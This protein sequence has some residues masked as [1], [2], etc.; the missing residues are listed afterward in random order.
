[1]IK[2]AL[3]KETKTP[4]DA[5]TPITPEGVL[6]LKKKFPELQFYVEP[7]PIRCFKD[8][9]FP[10]KVLIKNEGLTNADIL[11][12]VK[13]VDIPGLIEDKTY[14]FFSHTAK[15][16]AY[17]RGLLKAC[18]NKKIRLIDYE[19]LVKDGQRL[20]AFGNWAGIVGAYNTLRAINQKFSGIELKPAHAYKD[21]SELKA[22]LKNINLP[23]VKIVI[24][25]TG[26][27]SQGV[28]ELLNLAGIQELSAEQFIRDKNT[29][30]VYTVLSPLQYLKHKENKTCTY[31]EI[32]QQPENF[33]SN[34][35]TYAQ[36]ADVYIAAHFWNP[37]SP[38]FFKM[39]D[40]SKE[41]FNISVIG[42][43][44][45]DIAKPIPTTIRPSTIDNPFYGIKRNTHTEC[46]AFD[47]NT[48]TV[49]AVDNLPNE[50]PRDASESFSKALEDNVFPELMGQGFQSEILKNATIC[51]NGK[52]TEG[53]SYLQDFVEG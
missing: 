17:N 35:R 25:G 13:E 10:K 31:Q 3:I 50:L 38:V 24:T 2:I 37:K 7:S 52:L 32:F 20:T 45:C 34:F 18:L 23:A 33:S 5:R 6:R 43:I 11:M 42:D 16:Q 49:M 28:T 12:G 47:E 53:F 29:S 4:P 1:M 36:H 15:M 22:D 41:A 48:I 40:I 44:S 9:E 26:R 27:V 14:F 19:Y 8:S 46:G 30:A 51:E 21:Y 39:H